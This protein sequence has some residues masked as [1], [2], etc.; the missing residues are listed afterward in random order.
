M[1]ALNKATAV[2]WLLAIG[3]LGFYAY[4]LVM[5]VVTPGQMVGFSAVAA[6]LATM[7]VVH[8]IRMRRAMHDGKHGDLLRGVQRYR[9]KPVSEPSP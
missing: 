7:L 5:G 2:F 3:Y 1:R 6:V 9:E 8:G 4:G